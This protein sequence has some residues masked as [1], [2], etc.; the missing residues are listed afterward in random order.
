MLVCSALEFVAQLAECERNP[1]GMVYVIANKAKKRNA[2]YGIDETSIA[3]DAERRSASESDK[4]DPQNCGTHRN[5]A[6]SRRKHLARLGCYQHGVDVLCSRLWL[7]FAHEKTPQSYRNIGAV[8]QL[9]GAQQ[10][11]ACLFRKDFALS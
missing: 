10:T 7:S 2:R 1:R 3:G 5:V 8:A 9:H 4:R 6:T 11:R